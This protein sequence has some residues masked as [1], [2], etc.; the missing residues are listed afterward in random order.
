MLK[1]Y[2]R[3]RICRKTTEAEVSKM[4]PNVSRHSVLPFSSSHV[5]RLFSHRRIFLAPFVHTCW[6]G[7]QVKNRSHGASSLSSFWPAN[8]KNKPIEKEDVT[9]CLTFVFTDGTL[10]LMSMLLT[11]KKLPE[12]LVLKARLLKS[13]PSIGSKWNEEKGPGSVALRCCWW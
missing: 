12:A 2:Q 1:C 3:Q 8:W 6:M 10:H 9:F 7:Y 11:E 13:E 4:G 5:P